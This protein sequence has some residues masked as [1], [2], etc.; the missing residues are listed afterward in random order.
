MKINTRKEKNALV[1]YVKGRMDAVFSAEFENKMAALVDS[2]E[3]TFIID[4]GELEYISSAGIRS[5][6]VLTKKLEARAGKLA[7][8]SLKDLVEEVFKI[9]GFISIIP[10]YESVESALTQI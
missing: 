5:I 2:G 6:L 8:C 7:L 9:S 3:N 10:V 4:L 1:V